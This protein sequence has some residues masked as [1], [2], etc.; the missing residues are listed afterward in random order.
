MT[1]YVGQYGYYPASQ[2]IGSATVEAAV[3]PAR[4]R[5]FLGGDKEVFYCPSR[6]ERFRWT[7]SRPAPARVAFGRYLDF[8]YEPGEPLIHSWTYFSYGY[9]VYGTWDRDGMKG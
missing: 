7:D 4:L 1:M 2:Y 3:W 9:N 8:G 5:R 6:D